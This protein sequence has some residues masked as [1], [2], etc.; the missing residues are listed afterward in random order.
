MTLA[1]RRFL[2]IDPQ[3]EYELPPAQF[4]GL[5]HDGLVAYDRTTGSEGLR[6]VPD[7]ALALPAPAAGGR[8]YAFRLRP[9]LRY[10]DGRPVLASDFARAMVRLFRVSSPGAGFFTAVAGGQGCVRRPPTCSLAQGV[11]A[12]ARPARS[13]ST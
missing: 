11:R 10:S 12:D 2:S 7:L 3:I 9:E 4:L 6:L 8:T 13:C 5:V 1:T